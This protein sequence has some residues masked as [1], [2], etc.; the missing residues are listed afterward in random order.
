MEVADGSQEE[1]RITSNHLEYHRNSPK[2]APAHQLDATV[3]TIRREMRHHYH[4]KRQIE[5][6]QALEQVHGNKKCI[7]GFYW[8]HKMHCVAFI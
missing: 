8:F 3:D 1:S 2:M 4:L 6:N 5:P 7:F